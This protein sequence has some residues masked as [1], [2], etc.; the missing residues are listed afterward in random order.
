MLVLPFAACAGVVAVRVWRD[1]APAPKQRAPL[2]RLGF[3]LHL[4]L[5]VAVGLVI[6]GGA[7]CVWLGGGALQGA[8]SAL[9]ASVNTQLTAA[10][11]TA[12]SL[13][14]AVASARA[15]FGVSGVSSPPVDTGFD[16]ILASLPLP[17]QLV[18]RLGP[19][20]AEAG[21]AVSSLAVS[22]TFAASGFAALVAVTWLCAAAS[23]WRALA[24]LSVLLWL[25]SAAAWGAAGGAFAAKV[26]ALDACLSASLLSSAASG[27]SPPPPWLPPALSC[28]NASAVRAGVA[29]AW[30]PAFVAVASTNSALRYCAPGGTGPSGG[31]GFLCNPAAQNG[32]SFVPSPGCDASRNESVQLNAQFVFSKVY[33]TA[34]CSNLTAPALATLA[35]VINATVSL[36]AS[37]PAAIQMEACSFVTSALSS[38]SSSCPPIDRNSTL[39]FAGLVAVAAGATAMC[40]LAAFLATRLRKASSVRP[41]DEEADG[42]DGEFESLPL[43]L[44]LSPP[45]PLAAVVTG[46]PVGGAASDAQRERERRVLRLTAAAMQTLPPLPPLPGEEDEGRR[47]ARREARAR[48]A[49]PRRERDHSREPAAAAR[50]SSETAEE[51]ERR[52]ARRRAE[53][54]SRG[55][56][57]GGAPP[58]P[59]S[60]SQVRM[61]RREDDAAARTIV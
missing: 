44:P 41:I 45:P 16:A 24:V 15:T 54:A 53:E 12:S 22:C 21:R 38:A 27:A 7:T 19:P 30:A 50:H 57:R 31:V 28:L 13:E 61:P 18:A 20:L 9:H 46:V 51:R 26:A 49:D 55:R 17:A 43:P 2:S 52:H 32:S 48:S 37:T 5:L 36:V 29:V 10:A 34:T 14:L 3:R 11:A 8:L 4:A 6:G 40:P 35:V 47:R 39:L 60:A 58:P 1:D 56:G 33:N 42:G 23:V 25:L 59:R